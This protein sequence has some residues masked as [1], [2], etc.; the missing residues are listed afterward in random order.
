MTTQI[1]SSLCSRLQSIRHITQ[2]CASHMPPVWIIFYIYRSSTEMSNK[3]CGPTNIKPMTL[4]SFRDLSFF[5]ANRIVIS[6]VH[7]PVKKLFSSIM[8]FQLMT[9]MKFWDYSSPSMR[10]DRNGHMLLH[11]W[12]LRVGLALRTKMYDVN[13]CRGAKR[14]SLSDGD[15]PR[16]VSCQ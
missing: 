14:W 3:N 8:C 13:C 1:T 5:G 4:M 9:W 10:N 7:L 16:R 2:L 11:E 15:A 12:S 6:V